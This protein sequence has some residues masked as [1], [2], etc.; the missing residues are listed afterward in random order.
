MKSHIQ[1][2]LPYFFKNTNVNSKIDFIIYTLNPINSFNISTNSK[3]PQKKIYKLII[4]KKSLIKN[5]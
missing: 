1:F 2:V 5:E 4:K 3:I